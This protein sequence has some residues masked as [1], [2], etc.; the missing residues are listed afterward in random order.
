MTPRSIF[1][2][3]ILA[4][5]LL[6]GGSLGY[7]IGNHKAIATQKA[8]DQDISIGKI[9]DA[10]HDQVVASLTAQNAQLSRDYN[11]LRAKGDA[12]KAASDSKWAAAVAKQTLALDLATKNSAQ[13]TVQ[14]NTLKAALFLA[15]TPEEK[16]LLQ[17]QLDGAQAQ[18]VEL[19]ARTDG[20]KCLTVPI[21]QEYLD[22]VNSATSIG[23]TK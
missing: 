3:I 23:A 1:T 5:A 11:A 2:I 22:A 12:D 8:L 13:A 10:T 16:T 17:K 6:I 4:I 7:F 9:Q 19:Q 21:P 15:M 14:V 20:L 18:L